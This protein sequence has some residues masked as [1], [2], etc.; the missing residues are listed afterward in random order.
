MKDDPILN[1]LKII[2]TR[3]EDLTFLNSHD[4]SI[5]AELTADLIHETI[6]QMKQ[7]TFYDFSTQI[8]ILT[9]IEKD[10]RENFVIMN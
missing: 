4:A 3:L 8:N 2:E 7:I 1:N 10:L 6:Q 9:Y 5:V